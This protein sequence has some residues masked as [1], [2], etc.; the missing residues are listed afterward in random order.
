MKVI[1]Y[2]L[3]LGLVVTG[4]TSC[5][6]EPSQDKI[7]EKW[8]NSIYTAEAGEFVLVKREA[9]GFTMGDANLA[10]SSPEHIVKFSKSFYMCKTEVTQAQWKAVMGNNPSDNEGLIIDGASVDNY[11]VNNISIDDAKAFV[12]ALNAATGRKF[13]IPTEAQWEWAAMGGKLSNGYKFSGSN[14]MSEVAWYLNN[15]DSYLNEVGKLKANELGIY[16]MTGNVEEWTAD[17]YDAYKATEAIDPTGSTTGS[18]YV[19]RGG[20]AFDNDEDIL[21]VKSRN[22]VKSSDKK[23][24]RGLRLIILEPLKSDK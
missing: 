13:A 5:I 8:P 1:K 23:Y 18:Y 4:F 10:T 9:N 17:K 11:P 6:Q 15:S 22:K 2:I 14:D 24:T 7:E 19:V 20:S 12:E 21:C 16:D 3:A